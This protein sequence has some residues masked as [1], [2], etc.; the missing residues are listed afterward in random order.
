MRP[1]RI[2]LD[3]GHYGD[4][5]R[6]PAVPSY[7]EAHMAWAL[8]FKLKAELEAY[9]CFVATT[10]TDPR[11]DL[12]VYER[13]KMAKG[14]DMFVSLHSNAVGKGV[15]NAVDHPVV[16]Y[17]MSD[18]AD[19]IA[20]AEAISAMIAEV[21][22]TRELGRTATRAL[23]GSVEY[24]G[25]LRGAKA[26][27]CP[28]AYI[29][30]HSF[31]TATAP[32]LWLLDD[33]N[34]DILAK[35]EAAIIAEFFGIKS[36]EDEP[37]TAQEKEHVKELE[38]R[39]EELEKTYHLYDELPDYAYNVI[40]GMHMEGVF[41]GAGPHDMALPKQTMRTLYILAGQGVFGE[42]YKQLSK[43]KR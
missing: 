25:V 38:K 39:I 37:M 35:R 5:N 19:G 22:D 13:G 27:G 40:K 16:I 23:V 14:F 29:F 33:G 8:C 30:E 3:P 4:Y 17:L 28:H 18:N 2:L 26:V 6:S 20:F 12:A 11:K 9:G 41:A 1:P 43:T 7:H 42:R 31:H 32:A 15:N 24:Y 34:L 21:M 36:K 10:R